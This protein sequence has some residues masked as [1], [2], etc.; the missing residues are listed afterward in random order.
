MAHVA[1]PQPVPETAAPERILIIEDDDRIASGLARAFEANGYL[2]ERVSTGADG[3]HRAAALP[4]IDLVLLDLGL[5]DIDGIEVCRAIHRARQTVP[6][7]VLTARREEI[8]IVMGLDAGAVDYIAKPFR[9]AELLARVRAQLRRPVVTD[10]M[11]DG[12]SVA[13]DIISVGDVVVDRAARRVRVGDSEITLRAK[14]FDLLVVL[15]ANAGHV[16]SRERLMADV[17]DEH[18]F[19]STKT[20]DVHIASLRRRLGEEPGQPSRITTLRA[21]G[22]RYESPSAVVST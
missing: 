2:P 4:L 8:D 1:Y 14:E 20:L 13:N 21:V 9:L 7:V 16:V 6:I 17:W 18:W 5:P 15:I 19:G 11:P 12:A 22:Y 3:I 10:E